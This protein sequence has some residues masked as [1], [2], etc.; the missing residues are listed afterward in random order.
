VSLRSVVLACA[1]LAV[2]SLPA[3]GQKDPAAGR[4]AAPPRMALIPAGHFWMGSPEGVGSAD[5]RPRHQVYLSAYYLDRHHV[6]AEEY[7]ACVR[8]GGCPAPGTGSRCNHGVVARAKDPANCVSWEQARDYCAA[9]G[10]RLP[11]EAEWE[12]AARGGASTKWSFGDNAAELGAYAWF[13]GN[14]GGSTRPVG[15][16]RPNQYGLY[17][18]AGNVWDWVWDG[19]DAHYYKKS[20]EQDPAGAPATPVRV[21]RGGSR[22]NSALSSRAAIRYWAEAQHASDSVGF[23]CARP[24]EGRADARAS[25]AQGAL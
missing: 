15:L 14:S 1:G 24:A 23:R 18:M 9:Q 25:A 4:K 6:T 10:K 20:P 12:K 17:D 7:A 21:L 5:E 8:S 13:S 2:L 19:Y 16:K 22:A 11:T 3:S